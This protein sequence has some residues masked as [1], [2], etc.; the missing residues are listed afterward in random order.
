MWWRSL[1]VLGMLGLRVTAVEARPPGVVKVTIESEPAG[2]TLIRTIDDVRLGQTP[3]TLT[4]VAVPGERNYTL[5]LPGHREA[6]VSVS[7][8]FS[9][10]V[11]VKLEPLPPPSPSPAPKKKPTGR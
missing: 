6:K 2:A 4:R 8:S 9:V 7:A 1:L 3:L 10:R 11:K 5:R